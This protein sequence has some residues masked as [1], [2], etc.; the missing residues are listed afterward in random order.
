MQVGIYKF[1]CIFPNPNL[2]TILELLNTLKERLP[3]ISKI[4]NKNKSVADTVL[5]QILLL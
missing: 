4:N 3:Y 1:F 2:S 5:R